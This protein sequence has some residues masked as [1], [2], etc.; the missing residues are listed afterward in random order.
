MCDIVLPSDFEEIATGHAANGLSIEQEIDIAGMSESE[1]SSEIQD[2]LTI[3][4]NNDEEQGL[5]QQ[6]IAFMYSII[7]KLDFLSS[8]NANEFAEVLCDLVAR[9][10]QL[11]ANTLDQSQKNAV[12]VTLYL[13]LVFCSR[14]EVVAAKKASKKAENAVNVPKAKGKGKAGKKSKKEEDDDDEDDGTDSKTFSLSFW[15]PKLLLLVQ[16]IITLDASKV[17]NMSIVQE[18]FLI[19]MWKLPLQILVDNKSDGGSLDSKVKNLAIKILVDYACRYGSNGGCGHLMTAL[20]DALCSSEHM[21]VTL[22]D[23][24]KKARGFFAAD[25]MAEIGHINMAEIA[26]CGSGVKNIGSFLISFAETSPE[27]VTQYLATIMHQIDSDV[28]QIRSAILQ[29]IGVVIA[30]IHSS[31][32]KAESEEKIAD[33]VVN[34]VDDDDTQTNNTEYLNRVREKYLDVMVERTYDNNSFTRAAVLKVWCGLVESGSVPVRRIGSV[35][36]IAVDRLVDKTAAVRK[37]AMR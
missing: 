10:L 37:A 19:L 18:S 12:K 14:I 35:A 32:N 30:Y 1:I 25:L 27:L 2:M 28:W 11:T 4:F 15:R 36:E 21:A 9:S 24:I 20:I 16:S 7:L 26:K 3:D 33:D 8:D 29:A 31:R 6:R 13:F 17:W 34:G 22:A 5:P 23:I